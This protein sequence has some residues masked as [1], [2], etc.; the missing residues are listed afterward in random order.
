[1]AIV[2]SPS[3][4]RL[5]AGPSEAPTFRL[6]AT[7]LLWRQSWLSGKPGVGKPGKPGKLTVCEL[8]NHHAILWVNHHF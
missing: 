5:P 4:T 3:T 6:G 8:E 2:G 1:M 7:S